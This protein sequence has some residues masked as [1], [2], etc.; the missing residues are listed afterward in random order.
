MDTN[1]RQVAVCSCARQP[2]ECVLDR[3]A[4]LHSGRLLLCNPTPRPNGDEKRQEGHPEGN[5]DYEIIRKLEL[6]CVRQDT[7]GVDAGVSFGKNF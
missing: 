1:H 6:D 2:R 3:H 7:L 5:T 4:Y